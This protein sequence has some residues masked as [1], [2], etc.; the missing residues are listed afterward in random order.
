MSSEAM[1]LLGVIGAPHGIK[2]QVKIKTFTETP[3]NLT[4]YGVL[5]D[6]SGKKQ[7][8]ISIIRSMPDHV[9]ASVKG[10]PDRTAIEK[11]RGQELYVPRS[12]LPMLDEGEYYIEDLIGLKVQLEN[13]KAHGMV[14]GVY[15]FGAGDMLE[16]TTSEAKEMVP[17]TEETLVRVDRDQHALLIK[18]P[19]II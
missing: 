18:L 16:I 9:I 6:K 4:V 2:G 15:N 12:K 17:I 5:T 8:D 7:F 10:Y 19:I 3:E 1:I 13:G 11:L 14:T